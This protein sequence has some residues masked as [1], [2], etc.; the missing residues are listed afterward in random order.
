MDWPSTHF[1]SP[2]IYTDWQV[3]SD[4]ISQIK[5]RQRIVLV[6]GVYDLFHVGHYYSFLNAKALG[7]VLIVAVSDDDAVKV[8]KGSCR[9][10]LRLEERV[11]LIAALDCVDIVTV[12][13]SASPYN[14][15]LKLLPDVFAASHFSFL[16]PT[17]QEDLKARLELQLVPKLGTVSTSSIIDRIK[18][19]QCHA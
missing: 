4:I 19:A 14:M 12:Y 11:P 3:L 9:P 15:V 6:K 8:R 18:G 16:T 13:R 7:D 5:K 17:E 2:K 1:H 10:I